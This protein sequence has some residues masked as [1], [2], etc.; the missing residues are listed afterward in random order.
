VILSSVDIAKALKNK[1]L[2]IEPR[3]DISSIDSSAVD[4]RIGEPFFVW[5]SA[6][7]QQSGVHVTVNLDSFKYK[8]LAD[9]YLSEVAK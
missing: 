5:N 2:T 1:S 9:P 3:P 4:L 8:S 6:L 7:V